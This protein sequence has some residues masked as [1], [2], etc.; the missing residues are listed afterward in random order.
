MATWNESPTVIHQP[1]AAMTHPCV[2][3]G[4]MPSCV[5][6]KTID[7]SQYI[8]IYFVF[9]LFFLFL[10]EERHFYLYTH[11]A[12]YFGYATWL[13]DRIPAAFIFSLTCSTA[14]LTAKCTCQGGQIIHLKIHCLIREDSKASF[15]IYISEISVILFHCFDYSSCKNLRK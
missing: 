6:S 12:L 11:S 9:F 7:F 3:I 15:P 13:W 4:W 10:A 2:N 5:I 8:Y 14:R 1:W